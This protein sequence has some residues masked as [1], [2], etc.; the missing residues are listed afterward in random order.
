MNDQIMNVKNLI[1]QNL[2]FFRLA[3]FVVTN[4]CTKQS[5]KTKTYC[6]LFKLNFGSNFMKNYGA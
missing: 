6:K 5:R 2:E 3:N 4:M 1:N